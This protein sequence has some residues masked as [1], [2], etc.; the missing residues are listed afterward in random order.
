MSEAATILDPGAAPAAPVTP[1]PAQPAAAT[2]APGADPATPP[3]SDPAPQPDWRATIAGEDAKIRENLERFATPADF[4]KSFT[5]TQTALR[6]KTE[7]MVKLPGEGASDEEKQAFAKALGIP[8][9]PDK[10][11]I[12]VKPPEGL[13]VSEAD[14]AFLGKITAKLHATGSFAAHPEAANIAHEVYYEM[15]QEQAAQ[16][17]AAAQQKAAEGKQTL[18]QVYG[19]NFELEMKHANAALTAFG[20]RDPEKL[21]G[22]LNR[23]LLDGTKLGDDPEIIQMLVRA[24]RATQEDPMFLSTLS[25]GLPSNPADVQSKID[26]IMK[27]RGTPAYAQREQELKQLIAQRERLAGRG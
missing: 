15:M 10:Y 2:P 11:E 16:I 12:K 9:S 7:G 17:A 21:K 13:E 25:D 24:S 22:F 23:Q 8:E 26:D 14:K 27:L 19:N 6:N 1:A 3:A 18:Q 5:D 4:Y 20:P